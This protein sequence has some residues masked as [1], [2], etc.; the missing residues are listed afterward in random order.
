MT[1]D[2]DLRSR[3]VVGAK[4][5]GRRKYDLQAHEELVQLRTTS[6]ISIARTA[7]EGGQKP[8]LSREWI[9][10]QKTH[11]AQNSAEK[12][13]RPADRASLDV[14][15]PALRTHAPDVPSPF[16]PVVQ[17]AVTVERAVSARTPS[18]TVA[19]PLRLPRGPK[20]HRY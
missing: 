3:L 20:N 13:L 15:L 8:N 9:T 16:V 12:E 11:A 6:G 1:E 4:R 10:R 7:M 5:D 17:G 2:R 18:I 14:T 19:L